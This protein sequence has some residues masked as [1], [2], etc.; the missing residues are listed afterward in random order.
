MNFDAITLDWI[1][2]SPS[3]KWSQYPDDVIACDVADMDF[4]VDRPIRDYLYQLAERGD[5]C[6]VNA[7]P[8]DPLAEV[9]A[10]RMQERFQWHIDPAD[11][12]DVVDIVQGVH[13]SILAFCA[14]DTV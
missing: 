3:Y 9:F 11:V 1:R 7:I 2:Q 13:L 14:E 12:A 4:P 10:K 5:L 6:Y 8:K